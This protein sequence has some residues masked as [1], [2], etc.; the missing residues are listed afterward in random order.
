MNHLDG[1]LKSADG[2]EIYW[3]SWQV[4][5]PIACV[6]IC[7]GLGEHGGRYQPIATRLTELGYSVFAIDHRGHGESGGRRGLIKQ[8]QRCIDDV[9]LLVEQQLLPLKRPVILF[10]HSMGG[11][12]ATAYTSQHQQK[13][14][15]LMLSGAALSSDLVPGP[16]K[17]ICSGLGKL[18][19]RLPVLKIDPSAVSRDPEQ[20]ASYAND[21]LNLSGHVPIR[22][23]AEMVAAIAKLPQRFSALTL[24]MLIMHGSDDQLIPA[25]ASEEL[26][27]HAGAEDKTLKIYQGLYHEILNEL[28]EDREQVM[29]DM[30]E[31]LTARFG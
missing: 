19:P 22:T 18:L 2:T 1:R 3:Q 5:E 23:I 21:P 12:I 29:G 27:K 25:V 10:G 14:A 9:D 15:G 16:M 13:L 28:P 24:P 7:H 8:F 11:A 4:A 6:T 20:V 26:Y 30:L 17:L 31:W